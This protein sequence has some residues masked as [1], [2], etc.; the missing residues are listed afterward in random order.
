MNCKFSSNDKLSIK[1]ISPVCVLL[2]GVLGSYIT[3]CH[4]KGAAIAQ[5]L[6]NEKIIILKSYPENI[7]S[8]DISFEDYRKVIY[9][10]SRTMDYSLGKKKVIES[11]ILGSKRKLKMVLDQ[12]DLSLISLGIDFKTEFESLR[13][14]IKNIK[15]NIKNQ[16]YPN[17]Y[18][19][20]NLLSVKNQ[21]LINSFKEAQDKLMKNSMDKLKDVIK[22]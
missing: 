16:K 20:N 17:G 12:L 5:I 18:D 6:S 4:T 10:V 22:P 13:I 15:D 2:A 21:Y 1:I 14:I 19:I 8:L 9:E 11:D 7:S 3:G